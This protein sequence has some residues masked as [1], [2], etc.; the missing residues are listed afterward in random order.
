MDL[1][2]LYHRQQVAHSMAARAESAASRI[3]HT[4]MEAEYSSR[5]E[6]AKHTALAA[7]IGDL[8]GSSMAGSAPA[9]RWSDAP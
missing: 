6:R 5:I 8:A 7:R 9:F 3:A 4:R 1:N 2:D